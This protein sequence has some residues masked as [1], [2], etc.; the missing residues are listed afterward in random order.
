MAVSTVAYAVM[1]MTDASGCILC[2]SIIVSIPSMP[3]GI[4][5]STK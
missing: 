3:P 5:K 4:F 2:T 1:M